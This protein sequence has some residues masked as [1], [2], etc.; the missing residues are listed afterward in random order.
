VNLPR[1]KPTSNFYFKWLLGKRSF[2]MAKISRE[3][4][5]KIVASLKEKF[6]KAGSAVLTDYHGLSVAQMQELKKEL[7]TSDAEFSVAKNTLIARA[8]KVA[9]KDIPQENLEGPTAILFSF[10]DTIAP[11]KKLAEFIKKY[12]LPTIKSGLFEGKILTKEGV[13]ELSKIPGRDELYAKVV[14]SL[15]S[16]IYGLVNT[17]NGNLRNLVY[18]LKQIESSKGGAS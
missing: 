18:I 6:D 16:P 3:E 5:G 7:K 4:K 2:S 11:I 10:G 12:D 14:G 13:V 17:L 9:S 15:G 1:N 8:S